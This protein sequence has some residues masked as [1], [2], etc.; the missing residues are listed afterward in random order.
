MTLVQKIITV[1]IFFSLIVGLI[2]LLPS[3]T[4]YPLNPTISTG[5]T[6]IMGYYYAWALTFT[7]LQTLFVFFMLTLAIQIYI[8]VAR[9][10]MWIIGFVARFV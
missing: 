2:G 8:M 9:I 3:T 6:L 4:D 7:F 10:G 5:I 1:V